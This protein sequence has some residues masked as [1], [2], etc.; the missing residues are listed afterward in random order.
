[1]IFFSRFIL[2]TVVHIWVYNQYA[3]DSARLH[4]DLLSIIPWMYKYQYLL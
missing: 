4:D 2:T 1:M 3:R